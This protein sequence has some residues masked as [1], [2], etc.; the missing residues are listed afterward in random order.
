MAIA[1][2]LDQ[3]GVTVSDIDEGHVEISQGFSVAGGL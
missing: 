3:G 2:H 1:R